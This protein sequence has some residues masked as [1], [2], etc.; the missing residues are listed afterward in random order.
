MYPFVEAMCRP[1]GGTFPFEITEMWPPSE[2]ILLMPLTN[3]HFI[4][5]LKSGRSLLQKMSYC[6][7]GLLPSCHAVIC[8]MFN[9]DHWDMLYNNVLAENSVFIGENGNGF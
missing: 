9:V 6:H 5:R 3:V 2:K 7:V 4:T 1:P 8:Q